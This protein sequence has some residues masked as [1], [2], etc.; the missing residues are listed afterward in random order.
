M[1]GRT[2]IFNV[3][4]ADRG[5]QAERR[6][7]RLS[8]TITIF[9]FIEAG[10]LSY[11]SLGDNY[12]SLG[13]AHT[14]RYAGLSRRFL[15]NHN[16][17]GITSYKPV[18]IIRFSALILTDSLRIPRSGNITRRSYFAT[19]RQTQ[20]RYRERCGHPLRGSKQVEEY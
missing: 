16:Y 14:A 10:F 3:L 18:K 19:A 9:L 2:A 20:R 12:G 4:A 15:M 5:A 7:T 1:M 11:G 8:T 17:D 13:F 6:I